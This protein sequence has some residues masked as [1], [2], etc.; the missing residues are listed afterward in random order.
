MA[1]FEEL[2]KMQKE[3]SIDTIANA[4]KDSA[5]GKGGGVKDDRFWKPTVDKAGNAF[6]V[7][8][9]LP[10]PDSD[11]PWAKYYQHFF[12]GPTGAW[13]VEKCPTSLGRQC[14]V[15][16]KNSE[17]WNSG[18]EADK[19]YA[20]NRKRNLIYVSNIYVVKDANAPENEGKQFLYQY[21]AKIF[22][23][24]M[25]SMSPQF[26]EETAMNPFNL[27]AG[28]AFKLKVKTVKNPDGGSY[29]NYDSSEFSSPE[30]FLGGD[31]KALRKV[32]DGMFP[33]S[34]FT[35][36]AQYKSEEELMSRFILVTGEGSE[37]MNTMSSLGSR[38]QQSAKSND[39]E[40]PFG[41]ASISEENSES[42]SVE[43]DDDLEYFRRLA[44][45]A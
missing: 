1:T 10:A 9:F 15:C 28:G 31:E 16:T 27:F 13:F 33:I 43:E 3:A 30:P 40:I 23:K 38:M 32:F 34:E 25:E 37:K 24:I 35:D 41:N 45:E 44:A 21:G 2:M 39:Y 20:R 14:P 6:A 42:S 17:R 7:I 12:K 11:I 36:P 26:E 29:Q 22:A 8:R 19:A 4:A 18:I 5:P